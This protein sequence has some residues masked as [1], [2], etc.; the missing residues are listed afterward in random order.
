MS[1]VISMI[2]EQY[3]F[4]V[5]G[6]R[7]VGGRTILETNRGLFNLYTYPLN[8]RNKKKL[9][10][11]VRKHITKG[12]S[13]TTLPILKTKENQPYLIAGDRVIY[14]HKGI[15]ESI[16]VDFPFS[17]G[18][19]LAEFH[20]GTCSFTVDALFFPYRSM[21]TWP[22]MWRKKISM[23]DSIRE[24][25]ERN[26]GDL[27][28]FDEY[29]LTTY[30]YVHQIADISIKFLQD[31]GYQNVTRMSATTGKIAFQNFD[32]GYIM[33]DERGSRRLAGEYAW[34]LD[35]RARDIGQWIKAEVR[36]N[37]Y[38]PFV[39][40]QFLAGYNE[41]APLLEEEY[42]VIYSLLV[43]PGRFFRQ[44]ELYDQINDGNLDQSELRNWTEEL[45]QELVEM[46]N[47]LRQFP[48]L[49]EEIYGIRIPRIEWLWR[50]RVMS[51]DSSSSSSYTRHD[52]GT[53][54][55][56]DAYAGSSNYSSSRGDSCESESSGRS[57][58][59]YES[60]SSCR[61]ESSDS[62]YYSSSRNSSW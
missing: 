40:G 38:N 24:E 50:D 18:R 14:V 58:C 8:Y 62:S 12:T 27:T 2:Q 5:N 36:R 61:S 7:E 22:S 9:V 54:L 26:Q 16:P 20:Q 56:A 48:L 6:Y 52:A 37:G 3:G 34:V 13:F 39:I 60:E 51:M 49:I 42:S 44:I 1:D 33:F 19:A 25:L 10:D 28:V 11:S 59:S 45:E 15:R 57:D 4:T 47:V 17:I 55:N 43:Y 30:T 32:D 35:M 41:V 21:G 53:D 23:F 29:I 31:N 46:E